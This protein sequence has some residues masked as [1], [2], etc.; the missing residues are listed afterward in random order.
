MK[1][2]LRPY[3]LAAL[4]SLRANIRRGIKRQILMIATGGGKT[5]VAA[6]MI[7]TAVSRGRRVLFVAHRR[8]LI[9]QCSARLDQFGIEHG[10]IMAGHP[11]YQPMHPVQVA[12]IQTLIRRDPKPHADLVIIDEAHRSRG[13]SYERTLQ[14]YPTAPVVGLSA[15]P[16]RMDGRGL[17]ELFEEIVV[18]ATTGELIRQ[19]HLVPFTGY[20]YD[21]PDLSHVESR[22]G[23]YDEHGLELVMGGVRL[24]GNIV[25]QWQAHAAGLRTVVFAV[26]VAH[27]HEIVER[28]R[29]A[30]VAAEHLDGETPID[31]RAGILSRLASGETKVVSNCAV[32]C[33]DEQTEILTSAGWVGIDA[34]TEKH[35][36]ANWDDGAVTFEE[37]SEVIRRDRVPGERMVSLQ[38]GRFD[39]RV[40]EGHALLYRTKMDGRF[41]KAPARDLIDRAIELP[42]CGDAAPLDLA[43]EQPASLSE[44]R[45]RR[46][47]IQTAHNIRK[48]E[49]WPSETSHEEAARR[50]DRKYG[51]LRRGPSELSL[52]ECRLIGFWIGD[53]S[54]AKL[55]TGGVEYKIAQSTVYPRIIQWFDGVLSR[56]GIDVVKRTMPANGTRPNPVVTWSIGRGTGGG[57]QQREGLFALEPYLKKDGTDL[58]W[59]LN[60]SQFDALIE[61][62]W[63]ADGFHGREAVLPTSR[64]IVICGIGRPL[65]DLLQA[66]ASVRGYKA[67]ITLGRNHIKNPAYKKLWHLSLV[68]RRHH[69]VARDRLCIESGWH[70]ER[71]WCVRTRTKN[72]IT[73][74]NGRVL[75]MGNCEG[76]DC[77]AV[78]VCV[79]AR[80]T[81]SVG[82][83]LQMV[84]RALRP[85]PG[86]AVARIHDHAGCIV[87]HGPPDY[88]RNYALDADVRVGRKNGDKPPPLHTCRGCFAIY[89]PAPA[90]PSCGYVD[91]KLARRLQ[92]IQEAEAI[93]IEQIREPLKASEGMQ[94]AYVRTLL[95]T[96]KRKGYRNGWV[97]HRFKARF[98]V[99]PPKAWLAELGAHDAARGDAERAA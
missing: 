38:S 24:L 34:M 26:T 39:L 89:P 35:R 46:L 2:T 91:E 97:S 30:G 23:D 59:G 18:G 3:Q 92:E 12:S 10:V 65:F 70:P 54:V 90:C 19:G 7:T 52:D 63:M 73:R 50:I 87:Q 56:L 55:K 47:I 20:A 58:F 60:S 78:E 57:T 15:T 37:P 64:A 66:I 6:E 21:A 44:R 80:P 67:S 41:L 98:H 74:R 33:L 81:K 88:E 61:G 93:P 69:D 43:V 84:G 51:L 62:Y 86:K 71:V 49:G 85:S 75:V 28:F 11:R 22:G 32:L 53:G 94:R 36:V 8:E 25:G 5:S 96:A 1:Q 99:W 77:P 4:E 72:I 14:C 76:W 31:E 79:L 13:S 29:A 48:L 82:L 17:G 40:T 83:Y 16:W 9:D 27:S 68:R 45:R 95:E 42:V